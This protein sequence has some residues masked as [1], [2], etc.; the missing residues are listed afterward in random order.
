MEGERGE[1]GEGGRE[2]RGRG[3]GRGRGEGEEKGEGR[4]RGEGEEKGKGG[5]EGC[6][7]D[8]G[9]VIPFPTGSR[10]M[11]VWFIPTAGR[12]Q[13][14][15][16]SVGSFFSHTKGEKPCMMHGDVITNFS[17]PRRKET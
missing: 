6:V 2:G 16:L 7:G 5:K 14:I 9:V 10:T 3:R 15:I 11:W 8:C 4:G 1:G 13:P 12:I 17:L